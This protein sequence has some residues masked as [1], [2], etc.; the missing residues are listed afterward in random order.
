MKT[1]L[2]LA[3]L[4]LGVGGTAQ[5]QI[6]Y[7]CGSDDRLTPQQAVG[8]NAWARK[9]GYISATRETSLNSDGSYQ[10]FANG[11]FSQPCADRNASCTYFVPASASAPCVAGLTLVG[12]CWALESMHPVDRY[13]ALIESP[14]P[15]FPGRDS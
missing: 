5:A 8:R 14:L 11:C 12:S 9:C 4:F 15:L 1:W 7:R 10:V 6:S 13:L 2:P 3:V